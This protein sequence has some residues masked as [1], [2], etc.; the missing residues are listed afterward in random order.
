MRIPLILKTFRMGSNHSYWCLRIQ[1][2]Q[3][4]LK[5]Q[6]QKHNQQTNSGSG[7]EPLFKMF[8]AVS[9]MIKPRDWQHQKLTSKKFTLAGKR[10]KTGEVGVGVLTEWPD[11]WPG[12]VSSHGQLIL[13][14]FKED[15]SHLQWLST[16]RCEA[17]ITN[18]S[19][20]EQFK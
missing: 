8:I 2:V 20:G 11:R 6:K 16:P 3:F 9:R 13:E 17:K 7:K 19:D 12:D 4:K 5:K 14:V 1:L 18:L 10:Q 15:C